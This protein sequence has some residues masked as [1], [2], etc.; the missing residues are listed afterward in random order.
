MKI[1]VSGTRLGVE[2]IIVKTMIDFVKNYD[3][4]F[5]LIHGAAKGVDTQAA[6]YARQLGWEVFPFKPDWKIGKRAGLDRNSDMINDKPDF[7]IFI[8][9]EESRGTYDCLEKYKLTNKPYIL[10]HYEKRTFTLHE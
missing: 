6:N 1:L 8:P 2:S 7:G 5:I 10:Y 4:E 3:T 9:G